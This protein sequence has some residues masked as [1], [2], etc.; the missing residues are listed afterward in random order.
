[1]ES[2][3]TLSILKTFLDDW[4]IDVGQDLELLQILLHADEAPFLDPFPPILRGRY[5][6]RLSDPVALLLYLLKFFFTISQKYLASFLKA[7]IRKLLERDIPRVLQRYPPPPRSN[8]LLSGR[9][10]ELSLESGR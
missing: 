7:L 9:P 6:L 3:L 10:D 5:C 1:M 4:I 8:R 2:K